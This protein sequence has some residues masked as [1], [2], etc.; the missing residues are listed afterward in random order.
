MG[1][2]TLQLDSVR[3]QKRRQH[4]AL[5]EGK[6]YAQHRLLPGRQ[7]FVIRWAAGTPRKRARHPSRPVPLEANNG[8]NNLRGTVAFGRERCAR[9][10]LGQ[11]FINL[12]DNTPLDHKPT[13]PATPRLCGIRPSGRAWRWWMP[14]AMCPPAAGADARPGAGDARSL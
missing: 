12:A 5:C 4:P 10:R 7:G 11:F 9:Q 2:I 14:S 8:L 13:V 6:H 1:D 3:A